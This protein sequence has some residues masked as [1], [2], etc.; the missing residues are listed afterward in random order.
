MLSVPQHQVSLSRSSTRCGDRKRFSALS[1][2]ARAAARRLVVSS[3]KSPGQCMAAQC[4]ILVSNVSAEAG[5]Q[6]AHMEPCAV[7]SSAPMS[8][9]AKSQSV[10]LL[11]GAG[12]RACMDDSS[13]TSSTSVAS[14]PAG[15]GAG[16]AGSI[17]GAAH[18]DAGT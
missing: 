8:S 6:C 18:G 2:S 7:G 12:S 13:A 3:K 1:T 15:R 14:R 16:E 11:L 5:Q 10:S 17:A 9:C 4:G